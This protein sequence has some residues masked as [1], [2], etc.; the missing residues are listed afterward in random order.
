MHMLKFTDRVA[1]HLG[2]TVL[3]LAFM[4]LDEKQSLSCMVT[5][6]MYACMCYFSSDHDQ[7]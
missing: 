4:F 3:H 7:S 1:S 5:E 6:H 2:A